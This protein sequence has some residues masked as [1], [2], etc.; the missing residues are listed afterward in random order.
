MILGYKYRIEPTKTQALA[1]E[2]MLS[3]FCE[4]YNACLQQRIEAYQRRKLTLRY[5]DQARELREVRSTHDGLGRWSFAAEQQV[6]RRMD[7]T[8]RAFFKRGKG[9]PR[10]RSRKRF[11]AAEFRVGDGITLRKNARLGFVGVTGEVKVR[12][13]R[14][15]PQKPASC[16]LTRQANKWYI[17]FHAE[18]APADAERTNLNRIG[19]DFGLKSLVAL[20]NGETIARPNWTKRAAKGLRRRHRAIARSQRHSNSRRKRVAALARYYARIAARRRDFCHKLSRNLVNRFGQIAIENL[21]VQGLARGMHAKHV[22]DAA[23]A[24]IASML[25]YKAVNAGGL[26]VKVDP[27]G[28]SQTC[29]ECGAVQPKALAVREHRCGCGCSMDRDVAA[30]IVICR[31]AFGS[32]SGRD[33]DQLSGSVAT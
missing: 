6:M 17:V 13:H 15:L 1:L 19:I 27:R 26:V 2:Q 25:D 12:W 4:L 29:P 14:P 21:N 3:D 32:G 9:F 28:T 22:H 31:R 18:V 5:L 8:F 33:P 7:K 30:A 20:S 16:V 23:W 24:Q 11:H 10:F